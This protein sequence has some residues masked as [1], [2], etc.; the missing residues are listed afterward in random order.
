MQGFY[1]A[2]LPAR[3]APQATQGIGGGQHTSTAAAIVM[4]IGRDVIF[5]WRFWLSLRRFCRIG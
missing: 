5:A 2:D 3:S 1:E 4:E